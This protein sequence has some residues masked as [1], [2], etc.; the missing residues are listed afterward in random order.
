MATLRRYRYNKLKEYGFFPFE[1]KQLC[2]VP[3]KTPYMREGIKER[4]R[5]LKDAMRE[6]KERG[7]R[8]SKT[9]WAEIIKEMYI[10][11]NWLSE[12]R[13]DVWQMLR[14]WE[15]RYRD[16]HPLYSPD[17]GRK[18]RAKVKRKAEFTSKYATSLADYEKG[19]GR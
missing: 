15:D 19:R 13:S 16:K 3:F 12:G 9:E 11:R 2:K 8:F 1:A 10:A 7:L 14:A 4:R 6:Y 5:T 17:Y 18:K